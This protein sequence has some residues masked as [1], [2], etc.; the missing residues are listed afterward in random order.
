MLLNIYQCRSV[1]DPVFFGS[2]EN[3]QGR[4]KQSDQFDP[5]LHLEKVLEL[6][7]KELRH[8]L[9]NDQQNEN[10]QRKL[11]FAQPGLVLHFFGHDR[12]KNVLSKI[13]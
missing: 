3:D 6:E 10:T 8:F 12:C 2:G 13:P 4:S 7:R 11:K 5:A 1:F 9:Q